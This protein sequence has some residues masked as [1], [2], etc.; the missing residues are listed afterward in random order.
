MINRLILLALSFLFLSVQ[1][2]HAEPP[3]IVT[4]VPSP[5]D[6]LKW[7][8]YRTHT[9]SAPWLANIEPGQTTMPVTFENVGQCV[10]TLY[11][12]S[13]VVQDGKVVRWPAHFSV[14]K[15]NKGNSVSEGTASTGSSVRIIWLDEGRGYDGKVY[16]RGVYADW[17]SIFI[18]KESGNVSIT[19]SGKGTSQT[20]NCG[21]HVSPSQHGAWIMLWVFN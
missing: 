5:S 6:A 15:D 11:I 12:R 9:M 7:E 14:S 1:H 19:A 4:N 16:I 21:F 8:W 3:A 13:S 18:Q 17:L 20:I 2:V 10:S